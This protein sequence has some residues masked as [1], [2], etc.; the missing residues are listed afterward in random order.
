MNII[1]L[2]FHVNIQH[3][4]SFSSKNSK[5]SFWLLLIIHFL[6]FRLTSLHRVIYKGKNIYVGLVN[7]LNTLISKMV[8]CGQLPVGYLL[9]LSSDFLCILNYFY[10]QS[11]LCPYRRYALSVIC[12]SASH[13]LSYLQFP[14]PIVY[15]VSTDNPSVL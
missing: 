8:I 15:I 14:L 4:L 6:F 13:S 11:C 12:I 2:D 10:V 7:L 9:V 5:M 1:I 3:L